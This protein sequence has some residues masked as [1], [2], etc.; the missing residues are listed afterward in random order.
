MA[1]HHYFGRP[2]MVGEALHY[3]A[4]FDGKWGALVGRSSAVLQVKVRDPW[5]G[6]ADNQRHR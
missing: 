3:V 2:D 5:M 4:T 6:W 1:R